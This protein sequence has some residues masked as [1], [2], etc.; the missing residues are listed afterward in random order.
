MGGRAREVEVTSA[1]STPYRG[2]RRHSVQTL[3]AT[4]REQRQTRRLHIV[5]GRLHLCVTTAK[6]QH[7]QAQ[8]NQ[9]QPA[10]ANTRE[11]S[12][13]VHA[14]GLKGGLHRNHDAERDGDGG[15]GGGGGLRRAEI[16]R[17]RTAPLH[18]QKIQ[19][20]DTQAPLSQPRVPNSPAAQGTQVGITHFKHTPE[21]TE[22]ADK[23][24][25]NTADTRSQ[26]LGK[27][28]PTCGD[29]NSTTGE[30]ATQTPAHPT[31]TNTRTGEQGQ[32]RGL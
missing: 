3:L 28:G 24:R 11:H 27:S 31:H 23:I 22:G 26:A 14:G 20:S 18:A 8:L 16:V 10:Q 4:G 7:Q 2:P 6:H 17:G 19:E 12:H 25:D 5:R 29:N 9:Q 32:S 15:G 30:L 21:G 1:E 13:V